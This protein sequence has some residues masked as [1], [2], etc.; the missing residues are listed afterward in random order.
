MLGAKGLRHS[1]CAV[2]KQSPRCLH[3]MR[4]NSQTLTNHYVQAIEQAALLPPSWRDFF[5]LK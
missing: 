5:S 3:R 2:P 4:V 1:A